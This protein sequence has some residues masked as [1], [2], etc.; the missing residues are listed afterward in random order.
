LQ[1]VLLVT[2][3]LESLRLAQR[4]AL[5]KFVLDWPH[6][7]RTWDI[8]LCTVWWKAYCQDVC[9]VQNV[10]C[11]LHPQAFE[12]KLIHGPDSRNFSDLFGFHKLKDFFCLIWQ[13]ELPIG[14]P[15]LWSKFS[16]QL[17]GTDSAA[18]C[19]S[20]LSEYL[21]SD[22]VDEFLLFWERFIF[23]QGSQFNISLIKPHWLHLFVKLS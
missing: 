4:L 1:Q 8:K 21:L 11:R 12:E 6:S 23:H 7:Q 18:H 19:K 9:F 5:R 17:V 16:Q 3:D 15:F 20:S 22:G 14:F 13:D 2:G 10:L